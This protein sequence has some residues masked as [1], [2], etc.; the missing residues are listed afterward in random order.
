MTQ[1]WFLWLSNRAPYYPHWTKGSYVPPAVSRSP[2]A[3]HLLSSHLPTLGLRCYEADIPPCMRFHVLGCVLTSWFSFGWPHCSRKNWATEISFLQNQGIVF[4]KLV[5]GLIDFDIIS[6][7]A[8]AQ[9]KNKL[10]WESGKGGNVTERD[11]HKQMQMEVP[12]EKHW[13]QRKSAHYKKVM[14][15]V[16]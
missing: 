9:M 11:S 4:T 5:G 7:V 14:A 2:T 8:E 6:Q 10:S 13:Q 1:G 16:D 15:L 12:R 3:W